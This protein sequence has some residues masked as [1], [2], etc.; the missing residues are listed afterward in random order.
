MT[1]SDR[2]AIRTLP[3]L[4]K[5]D[6]DAM[7]VLLQGAHLQRFPKGTLLFREGD[8]LDF[9]MVLVEGAVELFARTVD[10]RESTVEILWPPDNFILAA[11]LT[12]APYLMSARTM[13]TSRILMIDAGR[14][15]QRISDD[16]KLAL[17]M[18]ASLAQHFRMM[19]RQVK[20]LKLRTGVQRLGCFILRLYQDSGAQGPA[21]LPL[22]YGKRLLA[23]RLGMTPEN[24]SRA[25]ATLREHGV[26]STAHAIRIEDPARLRDFCQTDRLIDAVEQNLWIPNG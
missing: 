10:G 19:V 12:D 6:E 23:S 4:A 24:L 25:F 5:L 7:A 26:A 13:E 15:R 3:L 2:E 14:L 20:D 9:L 22:P 21:E 16:P 1:P 17:T 18:M 8:S 11:V